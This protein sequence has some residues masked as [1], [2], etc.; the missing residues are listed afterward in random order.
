MRAMI[1]AL[2]QIEKTCKLWEAINNP[3]MKR[4]IQNPEISAVRSQ[5]WVVN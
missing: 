4:S 1:A 2:A 5:G 3:S